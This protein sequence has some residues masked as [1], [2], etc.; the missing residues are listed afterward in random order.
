MKL[1]EAEEY[2]TARGWEFSGAREPTDSTGE[3]QCLVM[4]IVTQRTLCGFLIVS[5]DDYDNTPSVWE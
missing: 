5:N 4:V 3:G 2:L 1:A